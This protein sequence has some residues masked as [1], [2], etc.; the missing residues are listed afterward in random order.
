[1]T[2]VQTFFFK[3][4]IGKK[5]KKRLIGSRFKVYLFGSMATDDW[6]KS[7]AQTCDIVEEGG[8]KLLRKKRV[9]FLCQ[10]T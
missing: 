1:M 3:R 7:F 9:S 4:L 5:K 6:I 2:R 8:R 10:V